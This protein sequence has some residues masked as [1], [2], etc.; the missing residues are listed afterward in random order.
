MT[1]ISA[2]DE[3]AT[4]SSSTPTPPPT[5]LLQEQTIV[6]H[7]DGDVTLV[8]GEDGSPQ[9][10][11]RA[12]K[13]TMSLASSVWK[14]M[15]SRVWVEH[16]AFEILLPDDDVEAI[17]LVL[18]IAHLRFQ[19]LPKKGALALQSLLNLAVVCDKYDLVHL[20][21]PFLDLNGWALPWYP[22]LTASL[23]HAELL[24][25]AWT[26]GF[27]ESFEALANDIVL[28]MTMTVAGVP[29]VD[30][31]HFPEA[32]PPGLL[33]NSTVAPETESPLDLR[34]SLSSLKR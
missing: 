32:M 22:D 18:R 7:D 4:I 10:P 12:S 24:F 9:Q 2:Q 1:D 15:F 8:V 31:K 26:F 19:D 20:I 17:L 23:R 34:T 14:A 16:E 6:L 27:N 13:S 28:Q 11:I 25:V 29:M 5:V 30:G 3:L 33:G 21:R